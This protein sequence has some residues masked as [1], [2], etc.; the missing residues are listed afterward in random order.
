[1]RVH[2][3]GQLTEPAAEPARRAQPSASPP[4]DASAD[5]ISPREIA[6][7]GGASP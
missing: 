2:P 5:T 4:R 7:Q 3:A 1:M 6:G